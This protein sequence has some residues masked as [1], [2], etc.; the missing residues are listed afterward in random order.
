MLQAHLN[1]TVRPLHRILMDRPWLVSAEL[2][3]EFIP[4]ILLSHVKTYAPR[5]L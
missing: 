2:E 5:T 1:G 3:Y 4:I